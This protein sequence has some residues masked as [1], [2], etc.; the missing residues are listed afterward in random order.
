MRIY[1]YTLKEIPFFMLKRRRSFLTANDPCV[2]IS[3]I[4]SDTLILTR[5]TRKYRNLLNVTPLSLSN[6]VTS[7]TRNA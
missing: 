5:Q 6:S 7:K 2:K 3:L 4:Y 1:R